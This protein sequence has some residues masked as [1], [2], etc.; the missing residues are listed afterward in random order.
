M[1]AWT[2]HWLKAATEAAMLSALESAGYVV[3]GEIRQAS[4]THCL[5]IIGSI[6]G[7]AGYHANLRVIGEA[8][9][10][11]SSVTIARPANPVRVWA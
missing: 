6:P 10:A 11:L 2:S 1:T 3:D 9:E 5:D 7:K 8:P 4:H